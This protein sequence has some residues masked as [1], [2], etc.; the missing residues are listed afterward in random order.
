MGFE[1]KINFELSD[2]EHLEKLQKSFEISDNPLYVKF[3]P[4]PAMLNNGMIGITLK[5]DVDE[6]TTS[7][8]RTVKKSVRG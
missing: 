8:K 3:N 2:E 6:P 1:K 4:E 7:S 5:E